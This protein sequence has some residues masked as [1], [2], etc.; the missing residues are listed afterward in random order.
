L[1]NQR[2]LIA[3]DGNRRELVVS[4]N[5][6]RLHRATP[7][8]WKPGVWYSLKTRVDMDAS[9]AAT[10][11]AKAWPSGDPEPKPW[12]VEVRHEEGHARGASGVYGFS[13]Q[14]QHKVYIDDIRRAPSEA[15]PTKGGS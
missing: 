14:A 9:G 5:Y 4:S 8:R 12:T 2:Y 13:P 6:D 10:I 11:R 3:L 7:F 1:V 15:L